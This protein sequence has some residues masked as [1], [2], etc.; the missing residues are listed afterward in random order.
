M[1]PLVTAVL[2]LHVY[3]PVR[4]HPCEE[5]VYSEKSLLNTCVSYCDS[6]FIFLTHLFKFLWGV[7]MKKNKATMK[8]SSGKLRCIKGDLKKN[9]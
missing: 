7:V 3:G 1:V 2:R 5:A 4:I 6:E 8:F 9:S